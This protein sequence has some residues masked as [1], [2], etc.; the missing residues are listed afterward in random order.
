MKKS[1]ALLLASAMV[2][3]LAAC[4]ASADGKDD[5]GGE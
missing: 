3:S 5:K 2:F 1:F 4:G